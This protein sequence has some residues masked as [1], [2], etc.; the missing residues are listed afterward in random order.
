MANFFEALLENPSA[1]PDIPSKKDFKDRKDEVESKAKW[2]NLVMTAAAAQL[3]KSGVAQKNNSMAH[4]AETGAEIVRSDIPDEE[5]AAAGRAVKVDYKLPTLSTISD[6]CKESKCFKIVPEDL[7]SAKK[8]ESTA[9]AKLLQTCSS[10][11]PIQQKEVGR[12]QADL[13][14]YQKQ[15][16][17]PL[18]TADTGDIEKISQILSKDKAEDKQQMEELEKQILT[19]ANKNPD[20]Y[21][22]QVRKQLEKWGGLRKVITM[23]ELIVNFSCQ[24]HSALLRRNPSLDDN[25]ISNLMTMVGTFLLYATRDQQRSRAQAALDKVEATKDGDLKEYSDLV[26]QLADRCLAER[27][28][29]PKERPAYLV[30]EYFANI[31]MRQPQVEKLEK[32]LAGGE[33][34]LVMEMIMGSG[35][36]KVLLPLLGLM[37]ADGKALSMLIVPQ[38]LFES[39][40]QDTQDILHGA[41]SQTLRSL[42]IPMS[43]YT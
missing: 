5:G 16:P 21:S 32:F 29:A 42:H 41:F 28:Y 17:I 37:R 1:F 23:E 6:G 9:L 19:L 20:S 14:A 27:H 8:M 38:P 43:S 24:D 4:S 34:N 11:D 13:T 22:A 40:S 35:K 7:S 25:D 31:A 10:E 33:L 26:N 39:V 30:F 36:S 18:Y 3:A 15:A 12:L 2:E